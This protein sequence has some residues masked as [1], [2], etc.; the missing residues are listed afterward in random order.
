MVPRSARRAQM[1]VLLFLTQT[2][3]NR[4]TYHEHICARWCFGVACLPVLA[5]PGHP[6]PDMIGFNTSNAN[7]TNQIAPDGVY[8]TDGQ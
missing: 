4:C 3:P 7:A 5:S 1:G 8:D 2:N 6:P